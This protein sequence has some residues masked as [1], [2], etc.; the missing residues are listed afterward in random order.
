VQA[1]VSTGWAVPDA[2]ADRTM[3]A[4]MREIVTGADPIQALCAVRRKMAQE[5]ADPHA[6]AAYTISIT[7]LPSLDAHAIGPLAVRS[8][9]AA[10]L[11]TV[12]TPLRSH[13]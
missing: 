2:A 13:R 7:R 10:P 9:I 5:L 6:W 8:E 3:R 12:S 4:F 1:V 11:E